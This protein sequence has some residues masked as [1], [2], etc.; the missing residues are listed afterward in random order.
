[1]SEQ[2]KI[3]TISPMTGFKL[4]KKLFRGRLIIG[5]NFLE[6]EQ[7][8]VMNVNPTLQVYGLYLSIVLRDVN[9]DMS[10]GVVWG[11]RISRKE[12][13][14]LLAWARDNKVAV[15]LLTKGEK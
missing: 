10:K 9:G 15:R 8:L 4:K 5:D 3:T 14:E 7:C 12:R 2:D 13:R 1:M 6:T 11:F